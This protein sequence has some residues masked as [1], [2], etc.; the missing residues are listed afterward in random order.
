MENSNDLTASAQRL[1]GHL[2][3]KG[4][5]VNTCFSASVQGIARESGLSLASVKRGKKVLG[6]K[7]IIVYSPGVKGRPGV[8]KI[9]LSKASSNNG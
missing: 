8:W 2:M 9:C 6:K 4:K 1:L 3:L 5:R 7:G